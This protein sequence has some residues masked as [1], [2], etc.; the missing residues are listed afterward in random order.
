M[1]QIGEKSSGKYRGTLGRII[2][3]KVHLK[4]QILLDWKS[5][6]DRPWAKINPNQISNITWW[7]PNQLSKSGPLIDEDYNLTLKSLSGPDLS[8]SGQRH[9][10]KTSNNKVG[11]DALF[12][13]KN[14]LNKSRTTI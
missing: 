6:V 3:S 12:V 10:Q 8:S 13:V 11:L 9:S 14:V 1:K 7:R 5:F 2:I 4:V